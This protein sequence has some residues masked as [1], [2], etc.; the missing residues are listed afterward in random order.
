MLNIYNLDEQ[1]KIALKSSMK[2]LRN[3][4]DFKNVLEYLTDTRVTEL[5]GSMYSKDSM[6]KVEELE[7][8]ISELI[9]ISYLRHFVDTLLTTQVNIDDTY[10][11][12]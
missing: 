6:N 12:N 1:Q 10:L 2:N 11:N 9:H 5:V 7:E 8:V 4:R 3:N